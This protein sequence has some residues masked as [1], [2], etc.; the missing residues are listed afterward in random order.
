MC[1]FYIQRNKT[2]KNSHK[3]LIIHFIWLPNDKYTTEI[4]VLI[5]KQIL[6]ARFAISSA[7]PSIVEFRETVHV[8]RHIVRKKSSFAITEINSVSTLRILRI[9]PSPCT[10]IPLISNKHDSFAKRRSTYAAEFVKVIRAFF[11]AR[12]QSRTTKLSSLPPWILII[13]Y[14]QP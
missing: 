3:N 4:L 7:S 1:L 12:F 2:C 8:S 13:L 5:L 11:N 14:P 6:H 9:S 10:Y